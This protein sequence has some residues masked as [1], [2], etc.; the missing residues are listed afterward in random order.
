MIRFLLDTDHLSLQQRGHP[1]LAK[2][3]AEHPSEEVATSVVSMEE[4]IRGRLAILSQRSEGEPRISA[5]RRFQETVHL[6]CK[7]PTVAFDPSS[8]QKFQELKTLRLRVGSQDLRIAAI[9]LAKDMVV[10]TR[11]VK[12]FG[13]VPGLLMEDWTIVTG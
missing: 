11:N 1:Q 2:R 8:E 10:L 5:Y 6:F 12:D 4:M 3:L 13:R 9:A 7:I